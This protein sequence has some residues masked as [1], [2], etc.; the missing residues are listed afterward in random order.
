MVYDAE[1]AKQVCREMGLAW[2]P[3]GAGITLEGKP[4]DESFRLK[5]LLDEAYLYED[6][7][8]AVRSDDICIYR[9]SYYYLNH[10]DN[11]DPELFTFIS[12]PFATAAA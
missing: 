9:T 8:A 6:E 10:Q 12:V 3:N 11:I 5:S 2:D 4:L 7:P 1:L